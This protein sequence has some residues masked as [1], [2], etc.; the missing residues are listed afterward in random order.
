MFRNILK[1]GAI[2][3]GVLIVI[4]AL[5]GGS[6]DDTPEP[7]HP[8]AE[9]SAKT[10]PEPENGVS[11]AELD[12]AV[13]EAVAKEKAK[14]RKAAKAKART[15]ARAKAKAKREKAKRD[16]AKVDEAIEDA[17]AGQSTDRH[18]V[19]NVSGIDHQLAQDTLQAAGFYMIDEVDC[20]G[21][22]R[23]MLWDRNWTVETQKPAPGTQAS[24]DATITLCSVKDG[25]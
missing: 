18:S 11:K 19:P 1:W 6:N 8:T 22:D 9:A 21:Q 3:L 17:E 20:T 24:T 16:A 12:R 10:T 13:D 14:A 23:M 2:S 7:N 4:G 5:F 25:E 15:K